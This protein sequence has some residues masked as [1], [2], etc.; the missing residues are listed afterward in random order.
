MLHVRALMTLRWDW[1]GGSCWAALQC[2]PQVVCTGMNSDSSEVAA[3]VTGMDSDSSVVAALVTGMDSDSS[4]VVA[5]VTGMNSDSSVVAA[6]VTGMNSD[7]SVVAA[8]VTGM[9]SDSSMVAA[10][11]TGMNSDSSV[12][13]AL[14][15]GMNSDSSVVAAL[16]THRAYKCHP[17][18]M[19]WAATYRASVLD[20][21]FSQ[22]NPRPKKK[23]E[24]VEEAHREQKWTLFLILQET[25]EESNKKE[26]R[27][28]WVRIKR[29]GAQFQP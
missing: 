4:V 12:V 22:P 1:G 23:A 27:E 14:V 3:L 19:Y 10:L 16:V 7:S 11:V 13:A 21:A 29:K 18:S 17:I 15:T 2:L 26:M 25:A 28:E 24:K 20:G 9:D 5:L 8:L 6:L